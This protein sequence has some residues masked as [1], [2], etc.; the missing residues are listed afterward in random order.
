MGEECLTRS[1]P[2]RDLSALMRR[3]PSPTPPHKGERSRASPPPTRTSEKYLSPL[4]KPL[5]HSP[6]PPFARGSVVHRKLH[7]KGGRSAAEA[8]SE[9][10]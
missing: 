4:R 6:S 2:A 7:G 1:L 8:L 10:N 3:D 9:R 5:L